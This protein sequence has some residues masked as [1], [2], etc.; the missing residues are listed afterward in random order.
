MLVTFSAAELD[1][2]SVCEIP[3]TSGHPIDHQEGDTT[4]KVGIVNVAPATMRASFTDPGKPD[5][6]SAVIAWG[7]GVTNPSQAGFEAFNDAFGGVVGQ[8]RHSHRYATAGTYAL[9]PNVTDDDTGQASRQAQVPVPTVTHE[10][11]A[12]PRRGVMSP[13]SSGWRIVA[14]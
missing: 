11:A 13:H 2:P 10:S 8:L 7:D 3:I 4:F 6:L 12:A 1:G 14:T 9:A 5:H